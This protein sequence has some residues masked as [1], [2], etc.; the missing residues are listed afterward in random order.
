MPLCIGRNVR[1][2]N[3][4]AYHPQ[5]QG[6]IEQTNKVCKARLRAAQSAASS[7]INPQIWKRHLPQVRKVIN[8]TRPFSLPEGITPYKGWYS[9]PFPVWPEEDARYYTLRAYRSPILGEELA[10]LSEIEEPE[11]S[12]LDN[13]FLV[14]QSGKE[15]YVLSVLGQRITKFSTGVR[16]RIML[17]K[18][19]KR[20]QYFIGEITPLAI[21]K[22]YRVG[23]EVARV[24][25]RIL[26]KV[27]SV[28]LL[29]PF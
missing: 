8:T 20:L 21:L 11:S 12:D 2:V 14:V 18:G 26:K 6:A 15:K 5:T 19:G 10:I 22:K 9:R 1:I 3:S 29:T 25:V 17:K 24:M 27:K 7:E 28:S 23:V 4:R 16:E 13:E